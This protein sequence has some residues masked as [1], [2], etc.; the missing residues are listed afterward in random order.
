[1]TAHMASPPFSLLLPLPLS[2]MTCPSMPRS[3]IP[4]RRPWTIRLSLWFLVFM[5]DVLMS[6][7]MVWRITER[8]DEGTWGKRGRRICSNLKC[9]FDSR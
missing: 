5:L 6:V 3:T 2:P 4:K 1:M 8:R 9:Q 7:R